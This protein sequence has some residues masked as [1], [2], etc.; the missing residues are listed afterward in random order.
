MEARRLNIPPES[1]STSNPYVVISFEGNDFVSRDPIE[2]H[3]EPAV[4]GHPV[5]TPGAGP[6]SAG[7]GLLGM[8]SIS[9]AFDLA[10]RSRNSSKIKLTLPGKETGATTPKAG[11]AAKAEWLSAKVS[12]RDP[13]WKHEVTL[14]VFPLFSF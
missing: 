10:A 1:E 8:G 7:G 9:R 11:T 13:V 14:L 3:D 2:S 12:A 4:K 6:P 5:S